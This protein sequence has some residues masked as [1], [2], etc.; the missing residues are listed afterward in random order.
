[1]ADL[2]ELSYEW[3]AKRGQRGHGLSEK[4]IIHALAG[5][6]QSLVLP[7]ENPDHVI[8]MNDEDFDAL[9]K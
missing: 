4:D 8:W 9:P 5:N 3:P 6:W 7:G 1:M 2:F